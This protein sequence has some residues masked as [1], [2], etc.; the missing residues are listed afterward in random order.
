MKKGEKCSVICSLHGLPVVLA[1][2]VFLASFSL[3]WA[4]TDSKK[5][6]TGET[7]EFDF[8]DAPDPTYPTLMAS[9]GARHYFDPTIFLG[10][11]VDIEPDGQPDANAMGDDNNGDDADGVV[12]DTPLY[13]GISVQITVT[14]SVAGYLNAWL[15]FDANGDWGDLNDRI[16]DEEALTAGQNTLTFFVPAYT[17]SGPTFARFRFSAY[18]E[19]CHCFESRLSPCMDRF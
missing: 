8:G 9:D 13:P 11:G 12:F 19:A 3:L 5:V 15:D 10:S 2:L 18:S 4:E 17:P 16:F 1:F 6:R 7:Q 14:A